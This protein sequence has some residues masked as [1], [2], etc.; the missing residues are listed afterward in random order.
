MINEV[1]LICTAIEVERA[2]VADI[3]VIVKALIVVLGDLRPVDAREALRAIGLKL[4]LKPAAH[5]SIRFIAILVL[6]ASIVRRMISYC[7][8]NQ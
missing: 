5:I 6:I 2:I 7:E 8:P 4:F 3:L 1:R